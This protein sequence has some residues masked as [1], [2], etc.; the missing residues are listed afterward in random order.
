MDEW[1][2][3]GNDKSIQSIS[4]VRIY[5]NVSVNNNKSCRD[6]YAIA[7]TRFL[8]PLNL[9]AVLRN[10]F[11]APDQLHPNFLNQRRNNGIT[12]PFVKMSMLGVAANRGW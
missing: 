11:Y 8:Y 2:G 6:I 5:I 12:D 10:T 4:K 3:G 1:C 7:D 9:K